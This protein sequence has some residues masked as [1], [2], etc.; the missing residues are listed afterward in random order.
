MR[1]LFT[2]EMGRIVRRSAFQ[3]VAALGVAILFAALDCGPRA[4]A[5]YIPTAGRVAMGPVHLESSRGSWDAE[6][7]PTSYQ[8]LQNYL[9]HY[10]L[11]A[12]LS[13]HSP[14][15]GSTSST[16]SGGGDGPPSGIAAVPELPPAAQGQYFRTSPV[17]IV[18]SKFIDS[19]LD[20]PR[21]I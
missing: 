11:S 20:P 12:D 2:G 10:R 21:M 18:L 1:S 6:S 13:R 8:E 19:I 15:S 3:F 7:N 9:K 16:N 17:A 4:A 14:N 5:A